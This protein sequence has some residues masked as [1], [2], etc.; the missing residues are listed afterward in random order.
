MKGVVAKDIC[1]NVITDRIEITGQVLTD[2]PG[3]YYLTYSVTDD[4]HLTRSVIRKVVV[5]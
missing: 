4:F 5:K 2:K 1:G 3:I